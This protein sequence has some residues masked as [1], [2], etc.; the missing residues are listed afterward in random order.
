MPIDD[1]GVDALTL[2]LVEEAFRHVADAVV[3]Q[4][5][6]DQSESAL[7]AASYAGPQV[8]LLSAA[9]NVAASLVAMLIIE[10][11]DSARELV[12][13]ALAGVGDL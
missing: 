12:D 13:R 6:G 10:T 8:M 9:V 7:A 3:H 4:S 11:G 2:S 5:E 1:E